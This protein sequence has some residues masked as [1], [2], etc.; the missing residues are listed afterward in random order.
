LD[1]QTQA[2]LA[3]MA[4]IPPIHTLTP[5]QAREVLKAMFVAGEVEPVAQVE[6]RLIPGP[7]GD[8]PAR[9][10][11]PEGK[12]LFPILVFFHGG[13]WV[14]GDLDSHDA[15]CRSLTNQAGCIVV[16]VDYRLSP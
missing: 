11:T 12:G 13:G 16:S 7:A 15:L 6:N 8:I 10:Y 14:L 9:I 1:P 5:T 4:A 2:L 3:Q